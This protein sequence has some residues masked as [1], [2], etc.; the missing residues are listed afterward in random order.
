M[1]LQLQETVFWICKN[2][3]TQPHNHGS[4]STYICLVP[5]LAS[6]LNNKRWASG[7]AK[8][9]NC[10][11]TPAHSVTTIQRIAINGIMQKKFFSAAAMM[12]LRQT[13]MHERPDL[14][15]HPGVNGIWDRLHLSQTH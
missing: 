15:K 12:S 6:D 10:Q 2:A 14:L 11:T 9:M 1:L 8:R 7:S 13:L 5:S 3:R 4:L